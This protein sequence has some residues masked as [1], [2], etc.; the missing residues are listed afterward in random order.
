MRA[1]DSL[2]RYREASDHQRHGRLERARTLFKH[3]WEDTVLEPKLRGGAAFHL[4]EI[5]MSC[6]NRVDA[7]CWMDCC[8]QILP[9]HLRAQRLLRVL[10]GE[11]AAV[12]LPPGHYPVADRY[13]T[14]RGTALD[15]YYIERFLEA[16]HLDIQGR[17]IEIQ[18][19][20]YTW[21]FGGERVT[22]SRILDR[23]P[24]NG[25]ADLQVDLV[26]TESLPQGICDCMICTQTL[27]VIPD[28]WSAMRGC[29][30]L[31]APGGVLLATFPCLSRIDPGA[32]DEDAWRLTPGGASHLCR[33]VFP[34][35]LVE[36][37]AYGNARSGAAFWY[38]Y[39]VEDL[40]VEDLDAFDP[41]FPV[42]VGARIQMGG[43]G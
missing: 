39:V 14:E 31:L 27:H 26:R 38:G 24:G 10:K 7:R 28:I 36:I 37:R 22:S 18:S 6:W 4:G 5:A 30:R 15:R 40:S 23:D 43:A 21:R 41:M 33:Q 16:C 8:L 34:D 25:S 42:L 3:I 32:C 11:D 12:A 9:S 1:E 29:K 17:V 19:D 2:E 35:S 20:A 13:G